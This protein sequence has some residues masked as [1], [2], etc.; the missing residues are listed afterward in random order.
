MYEKYKSAE[1]DLY[2]SWHM[3][4]LILMKDLK[5]WWVAYQKT[6]FHLGFSFENA[7]K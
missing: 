2:K 7:M 5:D 3:K 1:L 6:L 4:Y